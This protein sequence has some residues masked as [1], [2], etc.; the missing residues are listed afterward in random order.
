MKRKRE[1]CPF[2]ET[3]RV[4][5][6][7]DSWT[8][9]ELRSERRQIWRSSD[10]MRLVNRRRS[11][12][13]SWTGEEKLYS[14]VLLGI[15][16]PFSD[17]GRISASQGGDRSETMLLQRGVRC[18]LEAAWLLTSV[19][20]RRALNVTRRSDSGGDVKGVMSSM[21]PERG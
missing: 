19:D 12:N 16:D 11:C 13:R 9:L 10:A 15:S 17:R 20:G 21:T 3:R 8:G 6:I 4:A 2:Y 14:S 7:P 1:G 5:A 18:C